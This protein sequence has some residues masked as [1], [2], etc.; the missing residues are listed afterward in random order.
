MMSSRYHVPAAARTALQ[1]AVFFTMAWWA[2]GRGLLVGWLVAGWLV[3]GWWL[4]QVWLVG[5]LG[6]LYW[7][8]LVGWLL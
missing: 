6:W 3:G 4:V 8:W 5:L 1:R 7:H 2:E